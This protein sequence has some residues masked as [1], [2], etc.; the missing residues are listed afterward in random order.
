L[1]LATEFILIKPI[2]KQQMNQNKRLLTY[3]EQGK[4]INPLSAWNELGVYRLAARICD[5]RKEG[6]EIKDEWLDVSNRY[7]EFV[8][9]KQYYL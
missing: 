5:L 7:G 2:N 6:V 1:N 9:V 4:A 8:K 3:L